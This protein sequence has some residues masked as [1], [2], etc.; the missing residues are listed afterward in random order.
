[1][2]AARSWALVASAAGVLLAG[3]GDAP[4][5]GAGTSV[6]TTASSSTTPTVTLA[7]VRPV[8][9]T[10]TTTTIAPPAATADPAAGLPIVQGLPRRD[11]ARLARVLETA[12]TRCGQLP[13]PTGGVQAN[14]AAAMAV[15]TEAAERIVA[16]LRPPR[17]FRDHTVS[18]AAR[19]GR[20]TALYRAAGPRPR[21]RLA[22]LVRSVEQAVQAQA[23]SLALAACGPIGI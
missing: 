5:P 21:R 14:G 20:L 8:T 11:R 4:S 2:T 16:S 1:M 19:L 15:R 7:T 13:V 23:M 6:A 12:R 3:C 18:L 22:D 10:T 17:A 9:T